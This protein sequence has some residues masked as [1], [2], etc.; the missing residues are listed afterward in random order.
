MIV[1]EHRIGSVLIGYT[2]P[3]VLDNELCIP[4]KVLEDAS[5]SHLRLINDR[6][7]FYTMT[8]EIEYRVLGEIGYT[9]KY[10]AVLVEDRRKDDQ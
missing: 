6:I 10:R 1:T 8:G 4:T 2:F 9:N 5:R 7:I 3:D